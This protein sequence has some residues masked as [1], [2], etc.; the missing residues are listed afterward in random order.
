MEP[1]NC[2]L[3]PSRIGLMTSTG[4]KH[5]TV[6][7]SHLCIQIVNV[8]TPSGQGTRT[9]VPYIEPHLIKLVR[10]LSNGRTHMTLTHDKAHT[11][12]KDLASR[13]NRLAA[14]LARNART[15]AQPVITDLRP[16][17]DEYPITSRMAGSVY[18]D[19]KARVQSSFGRRS[20][21]CNPDQGS[22]SPRETTAPKKFSHRNG[23]LTL[24]VSVLTIWYIRSR[25][26]PNPSF[27]LDKRQ[28]TT[29]PCAR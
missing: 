26:L 16:K 15:V 14:D 8:C 24:T 20:W 28:I 11:H 7:G 2:T 23:Y 5:R 17:E 12:N 4:R 29:K 18:S 6:R 19:L 25:V 21:K 13:L 1:P 9:D 10:Q 27:L 22:R 3:S